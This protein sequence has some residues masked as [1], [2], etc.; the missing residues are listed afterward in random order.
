MTTSALRDGNPVDVRVT[1]TNTGSR[2]GKDVVQLYLRDEVASVTPAVRKLKRFAKVDLDPSEA[3]TL[4]FT[5][6]RDDFSFIGRD[7]APVVEPGRFQLQVDTLSTAVRLTGS[8]LS[9]GP[10]NARSCY[11]VLLMFV[12]P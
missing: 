2:A 5:L 7:A 12:A 1:V 10:S 4:T 8:P 9:R 11:L 6:T 3:Q